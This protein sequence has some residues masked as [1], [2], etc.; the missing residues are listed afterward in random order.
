MRAVSF[1]LAAA[2]CL[3]TASPRAHAAGAE[4]AFTAADTAWNGV[5][6][7]VLKAGF[8]HAPVSFKVVA[9]SFDDGPS[10]YTPEI[11]AI[12][13]MHHVKA[14]FFMLGDEVEKHPEIARQ[15]VAAGH[16]LGNHTYDHPSFCSHTAPDSEQEQRLRA[17]LEF[18]IEK[19]HAI[20]A[21][22]TDLAPKLMRMP[23]GCNPRDLDAIVRKLDY[24]AVFWSVDG[25]DWSRPG[26]KYIVDRY[27]DET[28]PGA[29]LLMHD[30]GGNRSE[31]VAAL[32]AI[33]TGIEE[34][35][36]TFVTIGQMLAMMHD[37]GFAYASLDLPIL[38]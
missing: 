34:R 15:V 26:V 13:A 22:E 4:D 31:T 1:A 16:E 36:L 2:F 17:K 10:Q 27:S 30:G 8:Y 19:T 7:P 28:K 12:L 23:Y 37:R 38:R 20:L 25:R 11:L 35:G 18:E 32:D 6:P 21:M 3:A 9:L 29:V 24:S 33:L 14:T 5:T